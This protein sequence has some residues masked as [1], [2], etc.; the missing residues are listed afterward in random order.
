MGVRCA[1]PRN[2]PI[3]IMAV[4]VAVLV[5]A[6]W[7]DGKIEGLEDGQAEIK[8]RLAAMETRLGTLEDLAPVAAET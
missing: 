2:K 3:T 7:L 5:Q 1:T 8:E 4:G 6:A